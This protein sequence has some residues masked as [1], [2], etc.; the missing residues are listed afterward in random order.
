LRNSSHRE[1]SPLT[2]A[3]GTKGIE[4]GAQLVHPSSQQ[5]VFLAGARCDALAVA[6]SQIMLIMQCS[7]PAP[8]SAFCSGDTRQ[9]TTDLHRTA[10]TGAAR[11]WIAK[12]HISGCGEITGHADRAAQHA[13]TH[14]GLLQRRHTAAHHRSALQAQV[15]EGVL[16]RVLPQ[17]RYQGAPLHHHADVGDL[18]TGYVRLRSR[19]VGFPC[20]LRQLLQQLRAAKAA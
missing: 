5:H 12:D 9:H 17:D 8:T 10:G 18:G 20:L 19:Q 6:R 13:S 4:G 7:T 2:V 1:I 16:Q 11:F 3:K 15:Q 14:L